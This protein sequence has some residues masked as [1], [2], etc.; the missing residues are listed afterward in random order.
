MSVSFV[1][2]LVMFLWLIFG[3]FFFWPIETAGLVAWRP[4]G[5]NVLLFILLF[6]LGWK[7]YGFPI[8]G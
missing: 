7:V 2:W 5:G 6:L 4:I 8:H 1:F 3:F